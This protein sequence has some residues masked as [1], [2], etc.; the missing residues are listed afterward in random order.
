MHVSTYISDT[1]AVLNI[2]Y[3]SLIRSRVKRYGSLEQLQKSGT[4]TWQPVQLK[5]HI[6]KLCVKNLTYMCEFWQ[7]PMLDCEQLF[8]WILIDRFLQEIFPAKFKVWK[9]DFPPVAIITCTQKVRKSSNSKIS[10]SSTNC[11]LTTEHKNKEEKNLKFVR[12]VNFYLIW[13]PKIES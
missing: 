5:Q 10:I 6:F 12:H 13:T 9:W 11:K 7:G 4:A 8:C 3:S 2:T 1:E